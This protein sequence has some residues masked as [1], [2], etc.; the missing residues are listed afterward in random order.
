MSI[1]NANKWPGDDVLKSYQF[2]KGL[3]KKIAYSVLLDFFFFVL[4]GLLPI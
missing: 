2:L 1:G 3:I 4:E